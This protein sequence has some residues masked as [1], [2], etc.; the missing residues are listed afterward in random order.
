MQG[1]LGTGRFATSRFSTGRLSG[2]ATGE[3][4]PSFSVSVAG[5][6][7]GAARIG[8]ELTASTANF[9]D[10]VPA[11]VAWQWINA[12]GPG[13]DTAS[14]TPMAGDNLAVIYPR[15]TPSETY[16]PRNGPS[17]TVRYAPPTASGTINDQDVTLGG[18]IQTLDADVSTK[19]SGDG[20]SYSVSGYPG[21]SLTGTTLRIDPTQAGLG[22]PITVTATNSGGFAEIL[23]DLTVEALAFVSAT[24][25]GSGKIGSVHTAAAAVNRA[26]AS[27]GFDYERDGISIGAPDQ[28]TYT[29]VAAGDETDL[30]VVISA[31]LDGVT[32]QTEPA[33]IAITYPAPAASGSLPDVS[34]STGTGNQTVDASAAFTGGGLSY[35]VSGMAGVTINASSGVVT[36][37]TGAETGGTLTI[38]ATNSGGSAQASF[39]VSITTAAAVPAQMAAPTFIAVSYETATVLRGPAPADGGS[40]ILDY[41]MQYRPTSGGAW[42]N[43]NPFGAT[44]DLTGLTNDVEYEVQ[45][46]ARNGVGLGLWSPSGTFTTDQLPTIAGNAEQ[47][48]TITV[49]GGVPFDLALAD[50]GDAHHNDSW[51]GLNT[52]ALAGGPI[53][54]AAPVITESG[55]ILTFA[56]ALWLDRVSDQAAVT[57]QWYRGGVAISGE[58]GLTYTL[59]AGDAGTDITCR[60]TGAMTTGA[61]VA[62]SNVYSVPASSTVPA[63]MDAPAVTADGQTEIDIDLAAAPSDGGSPI[64]SYDLRW[65]PSGGSWTVISDVADLVSVTGL[66][67][68]TAYEVQSRAVNAVDPD[69]DNWSTSGSATTDAAGGETII[70]ADTFDQ[71]DGTELHG[72]GNWT[73]FFRQGGGTLEARSGVARIETNNPGLG[74]IV[75]VIGLSLSEDHFGEVEVGQVPD[76]GYIRFFVKYTNTG[77]ATQIVITSTALQVARESA[78]GG[79]TVLYNGAAVSADNVV[80]IEY[81][82]TSVSLLLNGSEIA[83]L[84]DSS[85]PT[86]IGGALWLYNGSAVTAEPTVKRVAWGN[87]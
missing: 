11:S 78:A 58:T 63:Q 72:S 16:G 9:S 29:P 31:T 12:T 60:E 73:R 28:A 46:A 24:F 42:I 65:R 39:D 45:Q 21:L 22:I 82:G 4:A 37:P 61:R 80:R 18:N 41:Q 38:T 25:T 76:N 62:V 81:S 49:D 23:F 14:Y 27:F 77:E 57:R 48:A 59:V 36:I 87:L 54:L 86:G 1:R 26:G 30:S 10:G 64:T 83:A 44:E 35:Q 3:A 70:F 33:A 68:S 69:P 85:P 75:S 79:Y 5:L 66:T 6:I 55:G 8:V 43:V 74:D 13:A 20:L 56:P 2:F 71:P 7:E 15:A 84:T 67:A 34:Y 17:A 52:T 19:F 50:A 32:I 53:M 47:K 40:A 51:T